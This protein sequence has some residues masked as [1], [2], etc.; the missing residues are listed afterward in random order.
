MNFADAE[1]IRPTPAGGP[2]NPWPWLAG[3]VK[4]VSVAAIHG[5][6][7]VSG[8]QQTK[9]L[10]A[11]G[12]LLASIL[13]FNLMSVFV[14]VLSE[15][16][17][18]QELSAYRNIVGV[19]PSLALIIGRGEL[20]LKRGG[21]YMDQW[22][23]ALF[24]GLVVALAQLLLYSA[25]AGLELATV[26]SLGQ[27]RALFVVLFAVLILR[28]T[29]GAWRIFA[30]A[31]GFAGAIWIVRPG[32]DAFS[33]YALL[34]IGAA[35]CYGFAAVIVRSFPDNVSSALIY[36]Y[37]SAASAVGAV[38][39]AVFTTGFRPIAGWGD[40]GLIV[41]MG[42]LGGSAVLLQML[43]FRRAAPAVLAPFSYFGLVAAYGMGW[44]FFRENPVG[45]L[46]PGVIL[47]VAGGAL[48]LWRQNRGRKIV[49]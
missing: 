14:R 16:H 29:V 23:L 1:K 36:V 3:A 49:G 48:I 24:R 27:T 21:L 40:L 13:C 17:S 37:S 19:L 25:I 43:A 15:H 4:K 31:L 22:R 10:G 26:S 11:I 30:L 28:E 34:P 18:P 6:R 35:A 9:A 12:L 38:A 45:T 32:T 41:T 46:F 33:S 47:I 2:R 20:K 8:D 42:L 39:L 44:L 5:R 7:G